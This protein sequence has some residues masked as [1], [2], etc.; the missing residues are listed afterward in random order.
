MVYPG[1]FEMVALVQGV[2]RVMNGVES[3]KIYS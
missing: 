3:V 1:E 2:L